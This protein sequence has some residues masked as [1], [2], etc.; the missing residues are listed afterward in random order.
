VLKRETDLLARD[1]VRLLGDLT[2]L[3]GEMAMHMRDKLAA[4]RRADAARIQS[5]TA[6]E[7]LLAE[8]AAEREGLRRAITARLLKSL[9]RPATDAGGRPV[10]LSRLAE[11]LEE[12]RRSQLLV[13]ASGLREKV[14][15]ING[16]HRTVSLVT[17]EMLNH[18][19]EVLK[20][21]CAGVGTGTYSRCGRPQQAGTATVFEAVG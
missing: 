7:N 16:M 1:L 10:T 19:G 2:G 9:G 12:P 18:L 3:H 5:I 17:S 14:L 13:A 8:K 20:V 6:R 11:M 21:M 4:V 15:E